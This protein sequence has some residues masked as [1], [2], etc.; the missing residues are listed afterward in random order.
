MSESEATLQILV[1]ISVSFRFA[2]RRARCAVA[3]KAAFSRPTR[4]RVLA[5]A[6]A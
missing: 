6:W 5:P 4:I 2:I 1:M 3:S